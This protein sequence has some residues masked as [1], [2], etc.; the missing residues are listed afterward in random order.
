MN[1][2]DHLPMYGIGSIYGDV[3]IALTV[4]AVILGQKDFAK[5]GIA[6]LKILSLIIGMMST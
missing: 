6:V 3:S 2:K 4:I 1:N 5:A